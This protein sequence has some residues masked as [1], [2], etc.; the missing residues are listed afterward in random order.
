MVK[1]VTDQVE[2]AQL[3]ELF[4]ALESANEAPARLLNR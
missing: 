2:Q 3:I 4:T 1:S